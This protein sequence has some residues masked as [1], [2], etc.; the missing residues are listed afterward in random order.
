M[1]RPFWEMKSFQEMTRAEWESLCDGCANCCLQKLEDDS[2][3]E[4]FY[5]RVVCRY[6]DEPNCRCTQYEDRHR[7]V[8]DCV[9]LKP[10]DVVAF[11]WLP[12]TCAYRLVAEGQ[13][14]PD[15]HP[16]V[17]GSEETVHEAG[18]SIRGKVLS[19]KHVHPDGLEEHIVHWV[20]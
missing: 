11:H 6:L 18:V 19:E 12:T 8:P 3:G 20:N 9:W 17:S 10:E 4:V 13:P 2:T 1:N 14:L 7:L 5:T 16:L 15:W